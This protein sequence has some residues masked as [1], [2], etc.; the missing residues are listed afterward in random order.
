MKYLL[1]AALCL[2]FLGAADTC[3]KKWKQQAE[4]NRVHRITIERLDSRV[5]ALERSR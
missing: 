1:T 5:W 4:I 3:A 2:G